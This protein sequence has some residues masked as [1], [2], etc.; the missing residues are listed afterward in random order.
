M[1][2]NNLI[3][4]PPISHRELFEATEQGRIPKKEYTFNNLLEYYK[5]AFSEDTVTGNYITVVELEARRKRAIADAPELSE[6]Q[7]T[8]LFN[9]CSTYGVEVVLTAIDLIDTDGYPKIYMLRDT[10]PDAIISLEQLKRI[11]TYGI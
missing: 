11:R 4:T 9:L 3:Q 6:Q 1:K 10:I 2:N 5:L 7:Q 8:E